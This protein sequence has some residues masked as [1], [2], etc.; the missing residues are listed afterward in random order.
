MFPKSCHLSNFHT[1]IIFSDVYINF[2][3]FIVSFV[4]KA[5]VST[6][7]YLL[8]I[9]MRVLW[10]IPEEGDRIG[11]NTTHSA[12]STRTAGACQWVVPL[13][14]TG[15]EIQWQIRA[16]WSKC[17]EAF[18][19]AVLCSSKIGGLKIR[20]CVLRWIWKW[21]YECM[22]LVCGA[23]WC[24]CV[25]GNPV[26]S[27]DIW[28]S[29]SSHALPAFSHH[30]YQWGTVLHSCTLVCSP[31]KGGPRSRILTESR[32]MTSHFA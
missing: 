13:R 16:P 8:V 6:R 25:W 19:I 9:S 11:Y 32:D 5:A 12:T 17:T 18:I 7:A 3:F 4:R 2:Q 28:V 29:V 26:E 27:F 31:N 20:G 24:E 21:M 30:P 10:H 1:S 14:V 22:Y 23:C 15:K